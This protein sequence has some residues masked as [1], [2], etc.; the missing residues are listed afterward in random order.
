MTA[1]AQQVTGI[2]HTTRREV[3]PKVSS[4]MQMLADRNRTKQRPQF[5]W[6]EGLPVGLQQIER[7]AAVAILWLPDT[8]NHREGLALTV[9][10]SDTSAGL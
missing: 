2:N 4:G 6:T 5:V 8:S 9:E 1:A 3:S 7:P 10:L